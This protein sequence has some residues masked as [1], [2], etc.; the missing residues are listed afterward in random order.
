VLVDKVSVLNRG[1]VISGGARRGMVGFLVQHVAYLIKLRT[2]SHV[3]GSVFASQKDQP[4]RI[5][6][7]YSRV[8]WRGSKPRE[9][10]ALLA[11]GHEL[12]VGGSKVVHKGHEDAQ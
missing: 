10:G 1:R 5:I 7:A 12:L 11:D 3:F 8:G 4:L 6:L 9:G 2:I